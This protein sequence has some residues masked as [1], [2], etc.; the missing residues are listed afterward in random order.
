M[1]AIPISASPEAVDFI[2]DAL[3][4][5]QGDPRLADLTPV[6]SVYTSQTVC[7]QEKRIIERYMGTF[8]GIGWD[9]AQEMTDHPLVAL[10]IS[11]LKVRASPEILKLLEGKRLVLRTTNAGTKG[12]VLQRPVLKAV[13]A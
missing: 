3:M 11:G 8:I 4:W 1:H 6:L 12:S 13:R 7:D 10:G 9:R 2:T 5:A